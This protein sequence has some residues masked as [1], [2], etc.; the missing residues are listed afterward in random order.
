MKALEYRDQFRCPKC[1]GHSCYVEEDSN[2]ARLRCSGL[3]NSY[4]GFSF[5][6]E[7]LWEYVTRLQYKQYES[8]AEYEENLKK[9]R[10]PEMGRGWVADSDWTNSLPLDVAELQDED[11]M[12]YLM[13]DREAVN[14]GVTFMV[15]GTEDDSDSDEDVACTILVT[16]RYPK[17]WWPGVIL[18]MEQRHRFSGYTIKTLCAEYTAESLRTELRSRVLDDIAEELP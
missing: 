8:Q 10:R 14:L 1:L 7:H 4:C 6:K 15:T 18:E 13:H 3:G 5:L 12:H 9:C 16:A 17:P 2:G 11:D